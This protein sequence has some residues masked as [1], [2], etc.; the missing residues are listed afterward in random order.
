MGLAGRSAVERVLD[1]FRWCEG[2]LLRGRN[3]NRRTGRG[4][5]TL[6]RWRVLNLELAEAGNARLGARARGVRNLLEHTLN[7]R[8]G[9]RLGQVLLGGNLVRNICRCRHS[10]G[11][12]LLMGDEPRTLF[13][14]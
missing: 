2:Q 13:R 6:A 4:V 11:P 9:L 14:R 12:P 8:L 5:A 7:D 10:L 3:L 1:G